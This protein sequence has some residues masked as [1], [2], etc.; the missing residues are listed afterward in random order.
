MVYL[1][2]KNGV[3]ISELRTI[4]F[5]ALTVN[6]LLYIYSCRSFRVSLWRKNPFSNRWLTIST[7]VGAALLGIAIYVPFFER[8]LHTVPLGFN[9]WLIVLG[10]GMI[11][12]CLIELVKYVLIIRKRHHV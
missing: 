5:A 11:Q 8:L 10:L 12:V 3:G 4:A 9:R 7:I 6:S 2:H 1:L